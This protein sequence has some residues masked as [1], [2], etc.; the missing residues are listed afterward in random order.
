MADSFLRLKKD[1]PVL[2]VGLGYRTEIAS[3]TLA[4]RDAIDFLELITEH[5]LNEGP[6]EQKSLDEAS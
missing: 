6:V 2:G 1:L 3:E 5:Y 4:H